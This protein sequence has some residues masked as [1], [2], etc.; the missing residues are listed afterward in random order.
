VIQVKG[1]VAKAAEVLV[2]PAGF[3]RAEKPNVPW[4]SS[5][6]SKNLLAAA[7][8]SLRLAAKTSGDAR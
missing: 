1:I 2:N 7:Q 3:F 6:H 4:L 8:D 5:S